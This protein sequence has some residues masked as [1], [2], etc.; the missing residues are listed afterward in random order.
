MRKYISA[1]KKDSIKQFQKDFE[2]KR[3][4]IAGYMYNVVLPQVLDEPYGVSDTDVAPRDAHVSLETYPEA[5]RA[6]ERAMDAFI[7][8][9]ARAWAIS[10][11]E[12]DVAMLVDEY[13]DY[14]PD[15]AFDFVAQTFGDE[16]AYEV[17]A[18]LTRG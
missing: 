3:K 16:M 18:A 12:E 17:A 11:F 6:A 8:A 10:K 15:V 7:D 14:D 9:A 13:Y 1:A 5:I 4:D 2:D